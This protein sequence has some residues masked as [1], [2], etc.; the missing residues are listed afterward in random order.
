MSDYAGP[1]LTNLYSTHKHEKTTRIHLPLCRQYEFYERLFPTTH[2]LHSFLHTNGNFL[3][4]QMQVVCAYLIC[5]ILPV[6]LSMYADIRVIV[7]VL[8][9][10]LLYCCNTIC[11]DLPCY[12]NIQDLLPE[13]NCSYIYY[14]LNLSIRSSHPLLFCPIHHHCFLQFFRAYILIFEKL[15]SCFSIIPTF[16]L[17]RYTGSRLTTNVIDYSNKALIPTYISKV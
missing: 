10:L 5:L 8:L 3:C 1:L 14:F 12:P 13:N 11:H 6:V 15:I 4:L 16:V 9:L 17:L 2:L 7:E